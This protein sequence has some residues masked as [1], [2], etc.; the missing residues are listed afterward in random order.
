VPI[1]EFICPKCGKVTE[2]LQK[3]TDPPPAT[4]PACGAGPLAKGVSRTSFQLKGGGWYSDLYASAGAKPAPASETGAPAAT[5]SEK[6][7]AAP[8]AKPADGGSGGSAGGGGSGGGSSGGTG[9]TS[10][11]GTPSSGKGGATT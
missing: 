2:S 7:P 5:P 10:G 11:G 6:S 1:Y 9:G 3:L 8:A 4:C